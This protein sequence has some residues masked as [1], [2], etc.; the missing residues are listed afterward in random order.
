MDVE[1]SWA[2]R[3]LGMGP[4]GVHVGRMTERESTESGAA[5]QQEGATAG[6]DYL[7][8]GGNQHRNVLPVPSVV[9]TV[10][11]PPM[12]VVMP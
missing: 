6:R 4:Y 2:S 7:A 5:S 9:S 1:R 10:M 8:C 12:P 11:K 3:L